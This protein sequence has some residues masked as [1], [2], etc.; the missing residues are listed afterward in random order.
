MKEFFLAVASIP[1]ILEAL[2][3]LFSSFRASYGPKWPEIL[4]DTTKAYTELGKAKTKEEYQA[5]LDQ[6]VKARQRHD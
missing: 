4:I 5:A 3:E 1:A 2:R 6:I